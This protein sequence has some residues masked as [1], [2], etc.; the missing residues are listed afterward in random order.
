MPVCFF[1]DARPVRAIGEILC[2]RSAKMERPIVSAP[3]LKPVVKTENAPEIRPII[4]SP[5][6]QAQPL[7]TRPPLLDVDLLTAVEIKPVGAELAL[8]AGEDILNHAFFRPSG[9]VCE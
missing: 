9:F 2:P 7:A 8:V 6:I 3:S 4:T 1:F 5:Q